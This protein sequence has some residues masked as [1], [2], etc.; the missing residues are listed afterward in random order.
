[1]SKRV[2]VEGR[3]IEVP[4]DATPDEI[5]QIAGGNGQSAPEQS[6]FSRAA[7]NFRNGITGPEG[8]VEFGKG[9]AKGALGTLANVDSMA[10]KV[11]GVRAL[12]NPVKVAD[13]QQRAQ[14]TSPT[15]AIGK[16]TEQA[17]EFLVPGGAE[18]AV[19]ARMGG[20]LVA[21]IA[22]KAAGSGIINKAQGR[23]FAAGAAMG[24]VGEGVASGLKAAVPALAETAMSVRG[25]DRANGR[26][27]GEAMMNETTGV[28]P[29]TIARQADQRI[30]DLNNQL[31][32]DAEAS[33]VPVS[34]APA[35]AVAK[36]S[37]GTA[38]NRNAGPTI[39][40]MQQLTDQL[41]L[42]K[43]GGATDVTFSGLDNPVRIASPSTRTTAIPETVPAARA[44][45]LKR[46]VGDLVGSWTQPGDFSSGAVKQVYGAL[47]GGID[48]AVPTSAELNSRM[49]S[50]MPVA[51]RAGEKDLN[52]GILQKM[53][54][55]GQAHTGALTGPLAA[56]AYGFAHGGALGGVLGAAGGLLGQEVLTNPTTLMVGA[57]TFASPALGRYVLP[58]LTGTGLQLTRKD[59]R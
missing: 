47:D 59:D 7:T 49:S 22:T 54:A 11:P 48:S 25:A 53:I 15:Q 43:P 50:L 40:E 26:S 28:R 57:R 23:S 5:D 39:K 32:Q 14:T 42:Q 4:D 51:K 16:G 18:E 21:R 2:S 52:A 19:A 24:G 30:S 17:A 44:L 10:S 3:I 33:P 38:V 34:L 46:G 37:L 8:L 1:M 55:R 6:A 9:M 41:H 58:G 29:G 31:M 56:G 12:V 36:S 20:G 45:S 13:M 35:R 27:I